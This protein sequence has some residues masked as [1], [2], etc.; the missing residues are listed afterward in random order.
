MWSNL[1][2]ILILVILGLHSA[3]AYVETVEHSLLPNTSVIQDKIVGGVEDSDRAFYFETGPN[4]KF[5]PFRNNRY[6]YSFSNQFIITSTFKITDHGKHWCLFSFKRQSLPHMTLCFAPATSDVTKISLYY[7]SGIAHFYYSDIL[8]NEWTQVAV[9]L[10]FTDEASLT[11]NCKEIGVS[12]FQGSPY[13]FFELELLSEGKYAISKE[14]FGVTIQEI[15][16]YYYIYEETIGK[17]C[18]PLKSRQNTVNA[19][20]TTS[21]TENVRKT[22]TTTESPQKGEDND[23]EKAIHELTDLFRK[24]LK[25]TTQTAADD[26]CDIIGRLVAKQLRELPL[27]HRL[28]AHKEIQDVLTKHRLN[29]VK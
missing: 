12:K 1:Y 2:T 23:V 20:S 5:L 24:D 26:E 28:N 27:E 13:P 14:N 8:E 29:H 15:K 19:T 16:I 11:I 25:P 6:K 22:S 3:S 17:V 21:T 10:N 7:G 4:N 9:G 18:K